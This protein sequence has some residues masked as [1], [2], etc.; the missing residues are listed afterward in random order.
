MFVYYK[1]APD[2][3]NLVVLSY[4]YSCVYLYRSEELGNW[5][6]DTLVKILYVNFLVYAHW[7]M[8]ISISQLNNHYILVDQDSYATSVVAKYLDT[9]NSIRTY[10]HTN[11]KTVT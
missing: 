11:T 5:F 9:T 8:S 3:S 10:G 6:V 1:Y 7:F 4:F 2:A